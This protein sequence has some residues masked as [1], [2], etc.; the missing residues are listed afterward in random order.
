MTHPD[1]NA[2]RDV[3]ERQAESFDARRSRAFFEAQ[4]LRRF[5]RDLPEGGKVLDIG[6]GGGL[7]ISGWLIGEGFALTGV[8]FSQ[9]LLDIA[10]SRWPDGDWRLIDMRDLDIPDRFDGI[11]G[12]NSFFHLTPDE[13]RVC[14][15]RLADHLRP[16]GVLMVTVGHGAGEVTG[17]VNGENVY[18]AS[19]SPAEYAQRIEACGMRLTGFLAEDPDCQGHSVLMAR[20]NTG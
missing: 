1:S 9:P 12:W 17:D 2:T 14:L 13:Q 19:L 8:D 3:Y 20:K 5:V 7:P 6:C 10:R 15:P 16:G 11:I 4:W 18:H